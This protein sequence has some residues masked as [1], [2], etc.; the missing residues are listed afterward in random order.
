MTFFCNGCEKELPFKDLVFSVIT[1]KEGIKRYCREC[2]SPKSVVHDVYWDGK[3]EE[4][5]ADDPRTGR[6]I[7]FSSKGE[8]AAY[9]RQRGIV[10]AGDRVHG[11]PVSLSSHNPKL[12][13]RDAVKKALA[14]VKRMG[15]DNRRQEYLR[16]KKEGERYA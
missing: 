3:P 12:D 6:P 16:I 9:L 13:S 4:N 15:I 8:K 1:D 10:E 14:H 11:A 5:L 2:R 7:V